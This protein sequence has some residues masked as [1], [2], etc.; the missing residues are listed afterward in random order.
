MLRAL[1]C[2]A[3][4][5]AA[6]ACKPCTCGVAR[7]ARVIGGG[8]AAPGEF[9]WLGALRK[10]GKF[11]CGATVVAVDHLLTASHC[12]QGVEA[13]R[14]NV[15]VGEYDVN[16]SQSE[17][18][19]VAHVL[20]HPDF[21]GYT[22]D[23]DIAVLRLAEPLPDHLFRP[24]CLPEDGD[25][26]IG[27]D[28]V[29]SGWGSTEEKGPTSNIPMKVEVKIWEQ[30]ECSTAGYGRRKVTPRMLCA[31]APERDSCTGDSGGPLVLPRPHHTLVGIVSWGRGCARPGYP[32]VY[33]R[34]T[35]FLPWL[36][37]ALR[38]ACSCSA[39]HY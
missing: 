8:P 33:T 23:N 7:G 3:I 31:N 25:H 5:A 36:K 34:V 14:L 18:F 37:V 6:S 24:A 16:E 2:L 32:G 13:S 35:R 15:L 10:D 30:E 11:I 19:R 9:P 12:V 29:V 1:C 20:Q 27:A 17:G 38:H 39:P 28:A 22:Y 26:L 4:I 21:N